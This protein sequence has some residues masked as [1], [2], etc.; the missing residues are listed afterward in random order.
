[1]SAD[2]DDQADRQRKLADPGGGDRPFSAQCAM[3][4]ILLLQWLGKLI[5]K[6]LPP[7]V[8]RTFY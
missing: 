5:D 2:D 6:K 1:M 7:V 3:T 4:T 8:I